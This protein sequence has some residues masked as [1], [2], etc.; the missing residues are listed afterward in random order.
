MLCLFILKKLSFLT[1]DTEVETSNLST[2]S[3]S[4]LSLSM[5]SLYSGECSLGQALSLMYVHGKILHNVIEKSWI[6][7]Q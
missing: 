6:I 2:L 5:A 7:I 1:D 3:N 4:G